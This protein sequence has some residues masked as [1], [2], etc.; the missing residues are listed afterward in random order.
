MRREYT[1]FLR[2][3]QGREETA[4]GQFEDQRSLIHFSTSASI[5]CTA[6]ASVLA[7]RKP[8]DNG[9]T[10]SSR[11]RSL[12]PIEARNLRFEAVSVRHRWYE[13]SNFDV[14]LVLTPPSFV[15]PHGT[16]PT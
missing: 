8:N 7:R 16:L 11:T 4:K 3:K 9:L 6:S 2:H 13:R 10:E 15:H 14:V 12:T 1:P 5:I